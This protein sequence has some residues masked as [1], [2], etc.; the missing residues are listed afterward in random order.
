MIWAG[1]EIGVQPS[2]HSVPE[3]LAVFKLRGRATK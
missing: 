2:G 1:I 3:H